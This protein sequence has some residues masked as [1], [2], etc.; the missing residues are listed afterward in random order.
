MNITHRELIGKTANLVETIKWLQE[1]EVI[2][3]LKNC[4]KCLR[5]HM[6]LIEYKNTFRWKCKVC[7]TAASIFKDTI[8]FNNKLDLT[9]LLDLAY[10]WSQDLNQQKVMQELKFSGYKTISKWHNILQKFSY[11]ILKKNSRGR[12][13]G[14][15]HVIEIMKANLAKE[16]IM[17]GEF[18]EVRGL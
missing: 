18:Q 12:I 13:G 17:S 10:Y 1:I 4:I 15:G 11:I 2:P 7:S 3:V 16:S 14:P 8:F 6:R 9:R 5:G